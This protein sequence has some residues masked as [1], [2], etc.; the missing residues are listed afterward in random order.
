MASAVSIAWRI[1]VL[2]GTPA[3]HSGI[4]YGLVELDWQPHRS[5]HHDL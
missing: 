4:S 2:F 3:A 5:H 1:Q